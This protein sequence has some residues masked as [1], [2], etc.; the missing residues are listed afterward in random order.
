MNEFELWEQEVK[1]RN[2]NLKPGMFAEA[3]CGK[4]LE[5]ETD[6]RD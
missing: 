2:E 6:S 4:E 1:E 5:I 3:C